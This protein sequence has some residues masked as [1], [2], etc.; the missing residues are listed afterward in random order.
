MKFTFLMQD[1]LWRNFFTL[2]MGSR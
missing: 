1:E 2:A